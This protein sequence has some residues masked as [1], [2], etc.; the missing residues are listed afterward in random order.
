MRETWG[1]L[2]PKHR[3]VYALDIL[4]AHGDYGDIVPI[5]VNKGELDDSPWFFDGMLEFLSSR[6]TSPGKLYKFAGTYTLLNNG[7]HR[8]SGRVRPARVA[9]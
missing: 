3:K 4:F 8:F 7:N 5:R 9:T 1:H 2:A 6:P